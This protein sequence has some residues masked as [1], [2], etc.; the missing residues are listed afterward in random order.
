[1][2]FPKIE[3]IPLLKLFSQTR[4]QVASLLLY[5]CRLVFKL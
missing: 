4:L 2:S 3:G 5:H 1:M